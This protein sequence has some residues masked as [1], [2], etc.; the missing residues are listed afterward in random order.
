[1]APCFAKT[2]RVALIPLPLWSIKQR[3]LRALAQRRL[4]FRG[5][6][7]DKTRDGFMPAINRSPW[8]L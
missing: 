6:E 3:R 1:M 4:A 5:I 2:A 8:R 7:R